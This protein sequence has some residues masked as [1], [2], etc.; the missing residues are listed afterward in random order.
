[1]DQ[2]LLKDLAQFKVLLKRA[3]QHSTD[4]EKLISDPAYG[5]QVLS[6]AEEADNEQLVVLAL[7]LKD[8]LGL[9]P[10]PGAGKPKAQAAEPAPEPT[11]GKKYVGSLRG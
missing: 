2:S 8:R 11:D 10:Q 5:R 9:L 3:T 1:M 6:L 4:I 7:E